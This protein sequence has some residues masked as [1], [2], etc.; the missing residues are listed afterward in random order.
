MLDIS[1]GPVNVTVH[2]RLEFN[3]SV[4]DGQPGAWRLYDIQSCNS[5]PIRRATTPRRRHFILEPTH[6]GMQ[7]IVGALS[8]ARKQTWKHATETPGLTFCQQEF[9]AQPLVINL[10]L[11][12]SELYGKQNGPHFIGEWHEASL[13]CMTQHDRCCPHVTHVHNTVM[14]SFP[15]S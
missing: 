7:R 10:Q 3:K 15:Y 2:D 12:S 6:S 9:N 8:S 11:T 13:P 5:V 14:R 4:R 1:D